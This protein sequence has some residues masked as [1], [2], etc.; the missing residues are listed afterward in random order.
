MG[1]SP[2]VTG[3]PG[4]LCWVQRSQGPDCAGCG[5]GLCHRRSGL[6]LVVHPVS[7]SWGS[8][9]GGRGG[10]APSWERGPAERLPPG[11]RSPWCQ[12]ARTP[13]QDPARLWLHG[14]EPSHQGPAAPRPG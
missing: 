13:G 7:S 10:W 3:A 6:G 9:Q 12:G 1:A 5:G 2:A 4:L 8:G 11:K 14:M